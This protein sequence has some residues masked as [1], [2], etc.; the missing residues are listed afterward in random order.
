MQS[1]QI[2]SHTFSKEV[3]MKSFA[4]CFVTMVAMVVIGCQENNSLDPVATSVIAPPVS[5]GGH[6]FERKGRLDISGEIPDFQFNAIEG[7]G[8][9]VSVKGTAEYALTSTQINGRYEVSVSA[10]LVSLGGRTFGKVSGTVRSQTIL[11]NG[12]AIIRLSYPVLGRQGVKLVLVCAIA[13][14]EIGLKSIH[15]EREEY[16][17]AKDN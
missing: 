4:L 5:G 11:N 1:S 15:L 3:V 13:D 6:V 14:G 17:T 9:P 12:A 8:N 10:K 16:W 7:C 2:N